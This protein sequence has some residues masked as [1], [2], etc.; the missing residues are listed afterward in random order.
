MHASP[1][2]LGPFFAPMARAYGS[3]Y[4]EAPVQ[5]SEDCLYLNVWA[6]EWP[7]KHPLPVMVWVHGGS[8][9]AGSGSQSTY[10][11]VSLTARGV[12]L[13]TINY[14][15]GVFWLLLPSRAFREIATP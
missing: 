1:A 8:N 5:S 4:E 6:P 7:A 15:L 9:T 10:D 11:G 12:V 13:V 14:R 2:G 3:S